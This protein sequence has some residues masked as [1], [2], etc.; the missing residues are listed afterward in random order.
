MV[1]K[2]AP[3]SPESATPDAYPISISNGE[4]AIKKYPDIH[5]GNDENFLSSRCLMHHNQKW[6]KMSSDVE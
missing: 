2:A 6:Y 4:T 3:R 1:P 5:Q